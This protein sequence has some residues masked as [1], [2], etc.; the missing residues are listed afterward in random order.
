MREVAVAVTLVPTLVTLV[1]MSVLGGTAIAQERAFPGAIVDAVNS[2]YSLGLVAVLGNLGSPTIVLALTVVAAFLLFTWLITSIDSAT[3]VICH[4]LGTQDTGAAKAF[5]GVALAAVAA[6][7]LVAG[8]LEALQA[9][10]VIVGLPLAGVMLL[11]TSGLLRD[12]Y[13]DRI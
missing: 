1:W 2:D 5:W 13:Y 9:A 10:S 7:L 3:L 11:L 12:L 8:G 4:L 6:V